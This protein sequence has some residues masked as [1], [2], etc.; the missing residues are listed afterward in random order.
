MSSFSLSKTQEVVLFS[1]TAIALYG[2]DQG[3][4]SL[5]NTNEDYLQTMG[6]GPEDPMVG[7]LVA[8]YYLGCSLGAVLFSWLSDNHG[9]KKAIFACLAAASL[10]NLIMFVTGLGGWTG[11]AIHM[12]WVG[13][14]VMGLGVGGIDAVIPV[15]SSELSS[16]GARGKALAQEFQMNIFGLNMAFAINI[17]VTHTLGK[18]NQWAWRTPIVV[19]QAYPALLFLVIG[20]L[21]ESP[22]WFIF[23]GKG[24][25]AKEALIDIYGDEEGEEKAKELF[26][27]HEKEK[28]D[29]AVTYTNML[30]PGKPTFH[31]TVVVL[32]GQI[33]QAL[34]GYGAV[35]VYGPQIFE[36][37]GFDVRMAEYIT[38]ANYVSYFF[39]M[40]LAWI[41]I[42]AVGRRK[43]M[44]GGSAALT[45]CFALL[46]LFGALAMNSPSQG[47]LGAPA[48]LG[49]V[50]LF[51]A[52][53]A[54]GIGWLATVWLIP[55]EIYATTAR[56][57]AS[58]ISVIVW[59]LA[60][61]A[62]TLLSPLM[63]NNLKYWIFLIF[64]ATNAFAGVWTYVYLPESGGRSFRDNQQFFIDA[65]EAGS[66]RVAKVSGGV[67]KKLAYGGTEG[68][69]EPL[70]QRLQDQVQ[71]L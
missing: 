69:N 22:R 24:E 53:G 4:M 6:I 55:T 33:N 44:L 45:T 64:A 7:I 52:T 48:I 49:T 14:V 5:I 18:S 17:A 62:V 27:A 40:T 57:Q 20:R 10:G 11:N 16:D 71:E 13:R 1:S 15:F 60:N 35:S 25:A 47:G 26:E 28:D 51:I 9:R 65:S 70:L 23:H 29:E 56:A 50:T 46:T 66:W 68:E 41:L 19:M 30:T 42:D 38:Q 61:F 37:L 39:L 2:Y 54:F 63:F 58:A 59:G 12:F 8:V 21:P 31:P 34:T 67:Y 3:M 43:L 32:M 36:L